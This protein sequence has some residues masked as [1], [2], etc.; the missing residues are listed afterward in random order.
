VNSGVGRVSPQVTLPAGQ[1][2]LKFSFPT[3]YVNLNWINFAWNGGDPPIFLSLAVAADL[4]FP[5][6]SGLYCRECSGMV[7][8]EKRDQKRKKRRAKSPPER[9]AV[10]LVPAF[11]ISPLFSKRAP[12][13]LSTLV[14]TRPA[15]VTTATIVGSATPSR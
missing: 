13:R 12:T 14:P 2:R 1:H 11:P 4:I 7:R 15:I 8:K 6:Y 5:A 10:R 9:V 3:D